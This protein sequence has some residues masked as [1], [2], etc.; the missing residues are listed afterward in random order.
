MKLLD[1]LSLAQQA[2]SGAAPFRA[3]LACGF[4]PLHLQTFL[5][6]HLQLRLPAQRVEIQTGL[7]G[8]LAGAL[9]GIARGGCDAAAVVI[10][11]ADL[12]ARLGLRSLGGWRP[13]MLPDIVRAV[14]ERLDHLRASLDATGG[15]L[16]IAV[17]MPTL[18]LPPIATT[19]AWH[20]SSFELELRA[21]VADFSVEVAML[22]LVR[23]V[24]GQELDRLSAPSKRLDVRSELDAGHPY[25]LAH[26]EATAGLLALLLAPSPTKKGLIVDLDG[27]LWRGIVGDDGP[28]GVRWDLDGHAQTHGL[29]QQVVRSLAD[30]GVLV[31]IASKNERAVVE[32]ALARSDLLVDPAQ[33]FP[34]EAHW[35]PK[36]ESVRRILTA[37]N[38]GADSVV[39]IDDSPMELAEVRAAFPDVECLRFSGDPGDVGAAA[40]LLERLRALFGRDTLTAEDTL[41]VASLRGA[42]DAERE[43][44]LTSPETFLQGLEAVLDVDLHKLP[45]DPRA[46]ELVNKTNQWNLNGRRE[47]EAD[48]RVRLD[49]ADTFVLVASYRDKYGPLGKIAVMRGRR[50]GRALAIDTWVMSCRAFARRIEHRCVEQLFQRF[51]ADEIVFDYAPTDRN[52]P[53]R[54]HLAALLGDAPHPGLRLARSRFLSICPPLYHTASEAQ[55]RP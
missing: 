29:L 25:T 2:P 4:T 28:G 54:E 30:Q 27:T 23:I 31:A 53:L 47:T 55:E 9:A 42:A 48:W 22:P 13:S 43:G 24:S 16:P 21:A 26:A 10:E 18:P 37:W 14:R 52:A 41:R 15:R 38:I 5:A 20:A 12:D 51:D 17:A 7:F 33:I 35:G 19:A 8:D 45:P 6:G 3:L 36:S 40:A 32:E 46:L 1:A 39:F 49:D 44:T 11:W 34:I 50:R